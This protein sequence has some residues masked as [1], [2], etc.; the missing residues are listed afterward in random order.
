MDNNLMRKTT[1]DIHELYPQLD[2]LGRL[3]GRL[4]SH[5]QVYSH[6]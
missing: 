5:T 6:P 2:K 3:E 4:F 1:P